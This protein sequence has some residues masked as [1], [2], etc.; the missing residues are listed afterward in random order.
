MAH[1]QPL[2]SMGMYACTIS[3]YIK[4]G[5]DKGSRSPAQHLCS[6]QSGFIAWLCWELQI[7]LELIGTLHLSPLWEAVDGCYVHHTVFT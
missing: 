7:C 5:L 4:V 3:T 2:V 6:T 1:L